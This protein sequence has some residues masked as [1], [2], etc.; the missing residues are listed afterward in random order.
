MCKIRTTEYNKLDP[1]LSELSRGGSP[2]MA[3]TVMKQICRL[4]DLIPYG[5]EVSVTVTKDDMT[6]V[7]VN[8]ADGENLIRESF[9][10]VFYFG[11]KTQS[12]QQELL[13]LVDSMIGDVTPE[14]RKL[15]DIAKDR[16]KHSE[17]YCLSLRF[18]K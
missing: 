13:D 15:F 9:S 7:T 3:G 18:K 16:I 2:S 5:G 4:Y 1:T 11:D 14:E 12:G 6:Y 17:S 8:D 10:H